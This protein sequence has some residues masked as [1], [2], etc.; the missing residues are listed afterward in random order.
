MRSLSETL[1]DLAAR[2]KSLEDRRGASNEESREHVQSR[3]DA[4]RKDASKASDDLQE[5]ID[6]M[7][8]DA[9]SRWEDAKESIDE[10]VEETGERHAEHAVERDVRRAQKQADQADEEAA[11]AIDFAVYAVANADYALIEAVEAR[12]YA[13]ALSAQAGQR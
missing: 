4:A 6:A 7:S 3:I 11:A 9:S 8:E 12:Q 2:A 13:D 1:S 5:R 10:W